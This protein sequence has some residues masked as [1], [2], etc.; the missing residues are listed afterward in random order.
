M[1]FLIGTR[2]KPE[3]QLGKIKM[4]FKKHVCYVCDCLGKANVHLKHT[5]V[6][7]RD[8]MALVK[9]RCTY[10]FTGFFTFVHRSCVFD[11]FSNTNHI[12][13]VQRNRKLN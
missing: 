2:F 12:E 9:N 11:F 1:S 7:H 10:K 13:V 8:V 4:M 3:G 5:S 6:S